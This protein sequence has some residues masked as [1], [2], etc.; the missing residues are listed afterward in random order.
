MTELIK[1]HNNAPVRVQMI[2]GEPWFVAKDV[3]DL[4]G[5]NNVSQAITSLDYDE[6]N[7]I[8]TNDV[9]GRNQE[10]RAVNESGLYSL[11]FQSRKP[12]A[13]AFRKWVTSEVLPAIRKYGRYAVPG[14]RERLR[15]EANYERKAKMVW[16]KSLSAHLTSTDIEE[17]GRKLHRDSYKIERVLS[18]DFADVTIEFECVCRATRN[19]KLRRLMNDDEWRNGV[20]EDLKGGRA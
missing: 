7:D 20:L 19:A 6:K 16:L 11:I 8:I 5:L 2:K 4:L 15:I 14:S 3:C 10:V 1:F 13:Q 12:E 9:T 18:G 17:I